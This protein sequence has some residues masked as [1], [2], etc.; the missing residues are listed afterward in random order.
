MK[1]K[2][3]DVM[4][5][6]AAG[7]GLLLAL[8]LSLSACGGSS[9]SSTAASDGGTRT[10]K[11]AMMQPFT[12]DSAYYGQYA[13][14]A[15]ALAKRDLKIPGVEFEM[16]KGDTKCAPT[17]AVQTARQA[18]SER[19]VAAIAPAC[20]GDTLAV[21][22][23]LAAANIPACSINL[24]PEITGKPD[25]KLWRVAPSDAVTNGHYAEYIA[26]AGVKRIAVIHDTSSYGQNNAQTF[27][28]AAEKNGIEVAANSTYEVADTDYSGQLLRA[29]RSGVDA[30]YIE[31]YDLQLGHL[32]KRARDLGI[33]APIYATGNAGNDTALAAGG[34]AMEGTLLAASFLPDWSPA[35]KTFTAAW[36]SRY[37]DAPNY[38]IVD[39]YMCSVVVM[40]AV[41]QAGAD[42]DGDKVNAAIGALDIPDTP[43]GR[44]RFTDV[45]DLKQNPVLVGEIKGGA[46]RLVKVL[47]GAG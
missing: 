40:K 6:R 7:A 33:R 10:V 39:L 26:A 13:E 41:Q 11:I 17:T 20:S 34:A 25:P 31:G 27:V 3:K 47:S 1:T 30:L 4:K 24:A 22:P 5:P 12:G 14:Q 37:H 36:K 23:I 42:A 2:V 19:P 38:N 43:A 29:K 9:D 45:G 28:D 18:V 32:I 35:A 15:F 16:I 8:A 46:P 21:K 44:I